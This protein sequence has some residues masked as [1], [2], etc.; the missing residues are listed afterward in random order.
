MFYI[1]HLKYMVNVLYHGRGRHICEG[2]CVLNIYI[3][4]KTQ[5]HIPTD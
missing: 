5:A 1:F 2:W 4:Y 3:L